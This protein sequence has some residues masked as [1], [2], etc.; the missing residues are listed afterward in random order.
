MIAA[1]RLELVQCLLE[2]RHG[3]L[4]M[5]G[6]APERKQEGAEGLRMCSRM[7]EGRQDVEGESFY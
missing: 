2:R 3:E 4:W 1:T 5:L 7:A 6:D